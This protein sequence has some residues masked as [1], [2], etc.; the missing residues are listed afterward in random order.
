[1]FCNR[2]IRIALKRSLP[3]FVH[4]PFDPLLL[5]FFA[6]CGLPIQKGPEGL[7]GLRLVHA[8]HRRTR[9]GRR[10]QLTPG[11]IPV[12]PATVVTE[13]DPLSFFLQF[14]HYQPSRGRTAQGCQDLEDVFAAGT[15]QFRVPDFGVCTFQWAHG[16]S[17][18]GGHVPIPVLVPAAVAIER[19]T[20]VKYVLCCTGQLDGTVVELLIPL[21]KADFDLVVCVFAVRAGADPEV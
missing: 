3:Q 9:L 6:E 20:T 2:F 21:I 10:L 14:E 4:F 19:D 12:D 11:E 16:K 7:L 17:A 5:E 18:D 8:P 15:G 1:M 13:P